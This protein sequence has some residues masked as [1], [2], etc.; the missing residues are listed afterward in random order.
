MMVLQGCSDAELV[1]MRCCTDGRDAGML[2]CRA[3]V[4]AGCRDAVMM[5]MWHCRAALMAG[6]QGC[7]DDGDAVLQ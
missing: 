6:M 4:M 5:V 2:R 3:A 7:G 1:V